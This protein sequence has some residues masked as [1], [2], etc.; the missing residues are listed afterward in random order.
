MSLSYYT[1]SNHRLNE[2]SLYEFSLGV[3]DDIG[4][5]DYTIKSWRYTS[6]EVNVVYDGNVYY[7]ISI[8]DTGAHLTDSAQNSQFSI[9][10]PISSELGSIYNEDA[11]SPIMRVT[12]RTRQRGD[13]EAPISWIGVV[14]TTKNNNDASITLNCSDWSAMILGHENRCC[15]TRQ[16]RHALFDNMCNVNKTRFATPIVISEVGANYIV[17]DDLTKNG[18]GYYSGGFIEWQR[19][20]KVYDRRGIDS[21][22]RNKAITIGS[23]KSIKVGDIVVA[24]P[25]CDRSTGDNG[26]LK[27]DNLSNFGGFPFMMGKSP[28]EGENIFV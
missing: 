6:E 20:P 16:C 13:N 2:Y 14:S 24:Y 15:W 5:T 21:Q 27:F 25:G 10:L 9:T 23:T 22:I 26:C 12:V 11:P 1:R 7:P 4:N 3:V 17:S 18:E 28:F 19:W 8:S